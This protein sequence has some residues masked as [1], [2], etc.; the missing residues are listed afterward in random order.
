MRIQFRRAL[1]IF[2]GVRLHFS[3]SGIG[4]SVGP[5]GAHVGRSAT[6][7]YY[8]ST[9]IPGTGIYARQNIGKVK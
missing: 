9:G 3:K 1:K 7:K 2:P 6:G 5:R 8:V 4:V